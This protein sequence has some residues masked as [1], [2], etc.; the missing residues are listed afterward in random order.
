M[1]L[2]MPSMKVKNFNLATKY[3]KKSLPD[4]ISVAN[5]KKLQL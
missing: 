2:Y 1:V 4:G 5:V 3:I